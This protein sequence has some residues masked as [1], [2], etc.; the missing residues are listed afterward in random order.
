[1]AFLHGCNPLPQII[2]CGTDGIKGRGSDFLV[3]LHAQLMKRFGITL[4]QSQRP[5]C[6]QTD[7]SNVVPTFQK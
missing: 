7:V 4:V 3:V 2:E 1:M 5:L 6:Q